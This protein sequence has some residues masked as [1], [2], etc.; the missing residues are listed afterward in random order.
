MS[1]A[2]VVELPWNGQHWPGRMQDGLPT[3]AYRNAPP[4]LATSRQLRAEGLCPGGHGPV[5]QI[6]WRRGSRWAALYR[7]DVAKP[8]P[9][10]TTSQLISLARANRV[11][12]TCRGTCRRLFSH[13]LP[14]STGRQCWSCWNATENA[15]LDTRPGGHSAKNAH[16]A[17]ALNPHQTSGETQMVRL[18]A[19]VV[20]A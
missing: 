16:Q 11:L 19:S 3:F 4:G 18:P 8:S 7:L 13:R 6:V 2:V 10:A 1:A 17:G 5:A 9:G 15:S 14:T 20:T 12:R